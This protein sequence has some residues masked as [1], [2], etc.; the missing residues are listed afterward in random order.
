[1]WFVL[2]VFILSLGI[3]F[4]FSPLAGWYG[5]AKISEMVF[6]GWVVA[7]NSQTVKR[8]LP[9]ALAVGVLGESVIGFFQF[10]LHHSLN[11]VFYFLGERNFSAQTPGIAN[12][13]INGHLV[14]RPY[15]TFPHPNVFAGFLLISL[16]FFLFVKQQNKFLRWTVLVVG[17][18][19]LALTLSRIAVFLWGV[20]ICIFFLRTKFQEKKIGI[21]MLILLLGISPFLGRFVFLSD[22]QSITQRLLLLQISW[23]L[24]LSHPIFG[25]GINNFIFSLPLFLPISSRNLLQPVH[26]IFLLW[27]SQTGITGAFIAG[28]FFVKTVKKLS[29]KKTP[30]TIFLTSCAISIVVIGLFDHYFLTL[31]Q[32][33]LLFALLLGLAWSFN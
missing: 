2:S 31:Q 33:Q 25:S 18:L 17:S 19:M 23:K 32:G 29:D 14:L 13:S 21:L 9:W 3:F 10:F 27:L 8:I 7:R 22:G 15:A 24:F 28:I 11:G 26:T 30:Y 12:A 20:W 16:L 6:V 5:L 4:S 1:M